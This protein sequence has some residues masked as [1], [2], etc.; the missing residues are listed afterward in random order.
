[1]S[2]FSSI[3]WQKLSVQFAQQMSKQKLED[4]SYHLVTWKKLYE[5]ENI[6]TKKNERVGKDIFLAL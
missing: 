2:V 6:T 5:C 4:T 3:T 1:M